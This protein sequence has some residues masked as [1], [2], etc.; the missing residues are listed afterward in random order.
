MLKLDVALCAFARL[1][2]TAACVTLGANARAFY[3]F[4]HKEAGSSNLEVYTMSHDTKLHVVVK[5]HSRRQ[6]K[7]GTACWIGMTAL[8]LEHYC[9]TAC[10]RLAQAQR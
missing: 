9:S 4:T 2:D 6:M 1:M 5:G 7:C 10:A 3:S 8:L